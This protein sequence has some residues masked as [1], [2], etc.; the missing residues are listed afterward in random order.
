MATSE[1][2]SNQLKFVGLELYSSFMGESFASEEQIAVKGEKK[3]EEENRAAVV[4]T[5]FP[6]Q[7]W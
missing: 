3:D 6:F 2:L 5:L 7:A 1:E 4:H